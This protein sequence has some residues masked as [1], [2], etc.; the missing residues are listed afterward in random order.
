MTKAIAFATAALALAACTAADGG[1]IGVVSGNADSVTVRA[2]DGIDPRPAA[3]AH[4]A[5]YGKQ[6]ARRVVTPIPDPDAAGTLLYPFAC[7]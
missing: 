1:D 5:K 4:C 7:L 3:T 2:T 6:A